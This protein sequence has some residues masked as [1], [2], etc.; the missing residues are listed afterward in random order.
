MLPQATGAPAPPDCP[1]L[2]SRSDAENETAVGRRFDLT[3]TVSN[4]ARRPQVHYVMKCRTD[5]LM[6]DV[7]TPT[8]GGMLCR[9]T[10]TASN[11]GSRSSESAAASLVDYYSVFGATIGAASAHDTHKLLPRT[12][13]PTTPVHVSNCTIHSIEAGP[14][15]CDRFRC[16]AAPAAVDGRCADTGSSGRA[17]VSDLNAL[18]ERQ[19]AGFSTEHRRT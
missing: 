19:Q 4:A 15:W 1:R 14:A 18:R 6:A 3:L 2:R 12:T 10:C 17:D 8:S 5:Q 7:R 13:A 16:I 9:T 11:V